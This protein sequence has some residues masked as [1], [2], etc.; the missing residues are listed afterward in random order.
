MFMIHKPKGYHQLICAL[1]ERI[2]G[3]KSLNQ[4]WNTALEIAVRIPH[5]QYPKLSSFMI[6]KVQQ[7][8]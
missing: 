5:N 8:V 1:R 3:T 4:I 2:L 7:T 6:M